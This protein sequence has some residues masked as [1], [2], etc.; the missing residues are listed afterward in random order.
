MK[1]AVKAMIV[2]NYIRLLSVPSLWT[3]RFLWDAHVDPLL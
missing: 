2:A 3:H 1:R